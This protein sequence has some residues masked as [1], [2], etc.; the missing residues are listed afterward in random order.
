MVLSSVRASLLGTLGQRRR[1]AKIV[2]PDE[3]R[4]ATQPARDALAAKYLEAARLM[5]GGATLTADQLTE[6]AK[7]IRSADMAAMRLRAWDNARAKAIAKA[8][9]EGAVDLDAEYPTELVR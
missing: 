3:R 5:P 2:D 7:Q 1:W 9:A 8:T 4:Q 6:R